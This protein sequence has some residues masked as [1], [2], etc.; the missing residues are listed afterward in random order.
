M[1]LMDYKISQM[2]DDGKTKK[3]T[4]RFYEGAMVDE[5]YEDLDTGEMLT[6]NVYRRTSQ[7][8]ERVF[9]FP[10]STTEAEIV[11]QLNFQLESKI[12]EV[13][14][15][16]PRAQDKRSPIDKQKRSIR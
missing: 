1:T 2:V 4:V 15:Q 14:E 7:I 16:Y 8:G 12:A 6:R 3:L 5:E 11:D 13:N 10:S 9:E